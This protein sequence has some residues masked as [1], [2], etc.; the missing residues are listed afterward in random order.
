[1]YGREIQLPYVGRALFNSFAEYVWH[2][3]LW[4]APLC[5]AGLTIGQPGKCPEPPA[6]GALTLE[7]QTLFYWFFM[8]I[9]RQSCRV[10][11]LLRLVNRLRKPTTLA[12]I[13]FEW[14]NR[15]EPNSTTPDDLGI[16]SKSVHPWTS[17]EVFPVGATSKFL[18]IP[19]RLMTMKCKWTFTKRFVLSNPLACAGWTSILNLLSEMFSTLR[20]SEMLFHFINCLIAIFS[21]TFY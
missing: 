21:S 1:M 19:F 3:S 20:L 18:H 6:F 14:L 8:F 17:A 15:I 4:Q 7:Y 5:K 2:E 9:M 11:S 12:F 16:R 13:V 10:F